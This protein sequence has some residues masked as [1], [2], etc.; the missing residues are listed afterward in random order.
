MLGLKSLFFIWSVIILWS[1]ILKILHSTYHR[2]VWLWNIL[3]AKAVEFWLNIKKFRELREWF[4]LLFEIIETTFSPADSTSSCNLLLVV[5]TKAASYKCPFQKI[6]LDTIAFS[7]LWFE[8]VVSHPMRACRRRCR[9]VAE[10]TFKLEPQKGNWKYI[11]LLLLRAD[12]NIWSCFFVVVVVVVVVKLQLF[13]KGTY[14]K[15]PTILS[16]I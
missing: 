12:H 9:F 16:C 11:L 4:V 6:F 2:K 15:F 7:T 5:K 13:L 1:W 8:E 14:K 10:V 3:H